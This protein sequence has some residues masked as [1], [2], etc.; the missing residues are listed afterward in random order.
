MLTTEFF[1]LKSLSLNIIER[2]ISEMPMY[3][4]YILH[5]DSLDK[6]YV[7]YTND[8]TRRLSE[9]NRHKAFSQA[10]EIMKFLLF[11]PVRY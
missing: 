5:S 4:V 11:T 1:C 2:A 6:F 9:H 10:E 3:T 8:L 7:G